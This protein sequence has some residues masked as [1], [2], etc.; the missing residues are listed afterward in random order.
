MG[1]KQCG[2][3]RNC[4]LRAISPSPSVFKRLVSQGRQKVSLCGNGL[5]TMRIKQRFH[6]QRRS[7]LEN[8]K[9]LFSDLHCSSLL[10]NILDCLDPFPNKPLFLCVGSTSFFK[11]LSVKE[12]LLVKSNFSFSHTVFYYFGELSAILIKFKNYHL[13]TNSVWKSLRCVTWKSL[14]KVG[15]DYSLPHNPDF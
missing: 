2:K 5:N 4:L 9:S 7:R 14:Q 3:R 10:K 8:I 6:N 11:T 13:Q 1:R 15:R 12:K